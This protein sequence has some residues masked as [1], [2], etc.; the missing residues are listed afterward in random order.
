L[1]GYAPGLK[2]RMAQ[3]VTAPTNA[4]AGIVRIH[5]TTM[6]RAIPQRTADKTIFRTFLLNPEIFGPPLS[7]A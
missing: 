6:R 5:A 2:K 1:H 7:A 4:D 3:N